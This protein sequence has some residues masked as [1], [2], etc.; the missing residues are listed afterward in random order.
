MDD[1]QSLHVVYF[2]I[3][4]F[5]QWCV[6]YMQQI[7]GQNDENAICWFTANYTDNAQSIAGVSNTLPVCR[8]HPYMRLGL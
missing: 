5:I 8:M 7:S 4:P 1:V 3:A 2:L 6:F